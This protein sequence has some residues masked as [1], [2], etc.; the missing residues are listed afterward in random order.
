M[1]SRVRSV[2]GVDLSLRDVF[3][4]PTVAGLADL[5]DGAAAPTRVR[6]ELVAEDR[7]ALVPVS[8]AQERMLIVDRLGGGGS[9]GG[10]GASGDW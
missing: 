6:P 4:H 10:S 8:A 3:D 2:F 5:I 9:F 7:P 1:I